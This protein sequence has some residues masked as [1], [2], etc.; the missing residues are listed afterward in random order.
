[1]NWKIL[2]F[3]AAAISLVGCVSVVQKH[4]H[5]YLKEDQTLTPVAAPPSTSDKFSSYYPVP[6]YNQE[7]KSSPSLVPPGAGT[8]APP[9]Q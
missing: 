9:P 6:A 3:V 4:Q 8:I 5:D 7:D 2:G 1:M